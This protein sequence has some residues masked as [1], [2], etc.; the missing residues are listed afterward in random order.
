MKLTVYHPGIAVPQSFELFDSTTA[1]TT[2]TKGEQ[3][4][5]LM[6]EDV[7]NLEIMSSVMLPF[8]IGDYI[9]VYEK[10]YKLNNMPT[11]SKT[12][13]KRFKYNVVFEGLQYDLINTTF[14]LGKD[15]MLDSLSADIDT[16]CAIVS[17]L[18]RVYPGLWAVGTTRFQAN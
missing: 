10:I 14:L 18:N 1:K 15:T 17:N 6:E 8:Q 16:F 11:V 2:I 12:A 13:A 9:T 4:M 7:V 5:K 3:V